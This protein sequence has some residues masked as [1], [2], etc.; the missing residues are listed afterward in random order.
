MEV[1][2]KKVI[3]SKDIVAKTKIANVIENLNRS[4]E[5]ADAT[6][7]NSNRKFESSKLK[8]QF[9]NVNLTS[10]SWWPS[11]IFFF[12]KQGK[13]IEATTGDTRGNLSQEI[14]PLSIAHV[15]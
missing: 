8:M 14:V 15:D 10:S 7:K 6:N 12:E 3:S 13:N 1:K 11:N 5:Q 4:R 2:S 9:R